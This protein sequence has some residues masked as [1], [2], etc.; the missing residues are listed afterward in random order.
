LTRL[1]VDILTNRNLTSVQSDSAQLDCIFEGKSIDL[2]VDAIVLVTSRSP[3]N[4]LFFQ[5]QS[6][7]EEN[8]DTLIKTM[9]H[10]GDCHAPSTIAAAVYQG[11]RYARNFTGDPCSAFSTDGDADIYTREFIDLSADRNS[12]NVDG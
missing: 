8:S 4:D 12:S 2:A 1:G 10:I 3:D 7:L 5:L 6:Q 9:S 11:H